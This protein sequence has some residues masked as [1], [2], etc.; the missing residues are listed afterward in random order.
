LKLP[1]NNPTRI[2][3]DFA[4]RSAEDLPGPAKDVPVVNSVGRGR[5]RDADFV[6]AYALDWAAPPRIAEALASINS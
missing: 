6:L 1:P 5:R 2:W 4:P 3:F